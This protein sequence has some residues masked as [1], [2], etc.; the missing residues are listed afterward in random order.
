M[1][2]RT[3]KLASDGLQRTRSAQ[4]TVDSLEPYRRSLGITRV[5]DVTGLDC[6]G[7]PTVM[8][9][10]PAARNLSVTQG[11]GT[12][13][14]AAKASGMMEAAEQ[15]LAEHVTLPRLW[16]SYRDLSASLSMTDP[17]D[18]PHR[19]LPDTDGARRAACLWVE[20]RGIGTGGVMWVPHEL[21]HLDYR[22]PLP[23]GSGA[24]VSSSNGLASGNARIEALC[25]GLF[26]VIERDAITL[27]YALDGHAQAQRS[28]DLS[29]VDDRGCVALLTCFARAG[30]AVSVWEITSDLGV[31]S[32]LVEARGERCD[33]LRP[34]G[35]SR[36]M[37][38]HPQR[39]VALGRALTEAA[40][41]RLTSIAG[42]RD[43]IAPS[44]LVAARARSQ[45]GTLRP[46]GVRA[47]SAAPDVRFDTF[48]DELAWTLA[49]LHARGLS[50]PIVVDLSSPAFPFHVVRVI[51]PGLESLC[52]IP[53]YSPG[54][55]ARA[56]R[57]SRARKSQLE[58][59]VRR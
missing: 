42:S 38:A 9:V 18:L 24:F 32:F 28:I 3:A 44:A 54:R 37:G 40:Q 48:E 35:M 49:Q 14:A 46:G 43:D 29:T 5:A 1:P 31:A 10:R 55:R 19:K 30:V 47:F 22:L 53:G 51:A 11:K 58:R 27:F 25:H 16:G 26:E 34:L 2:S 12:T 15:F 59:E 4:A 8:V 23:A 45:R 7:I 36:G 41:S 52:E 33:P 6:I 21:V 57:S 17:L 13:L 50:E 20:G 39:A 56:L